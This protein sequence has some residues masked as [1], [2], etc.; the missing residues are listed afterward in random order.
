MIG[1]VF[2]I[3]TLYTYNLSTKKIFK[4]ENIITVIQQIVLLKE[5][6]QHIFYDHLL[7]HY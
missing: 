4:I 6:K 7:I 2:P 1:N 5:I 3:Y